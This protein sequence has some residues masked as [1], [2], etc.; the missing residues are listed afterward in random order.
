MSLALLLEQILRLAM[1]PEGGDD[2]AGARDEP[3]DA[4]GYGFVERA[5][6][7]EALTT[8]AVEARAREQAPPPVAS[9]PHEAQEVPAV[10]YAVE[11]GERVEARD[12]NRLE[13][14]DA[15][16]TVAESLNLGLHLG[17]AV[18]RIAFAATKGSEGV[19][20]LKEA[21]WLIERYIGHV[22]RPA[23]ANQY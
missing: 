4:P 20:S 19:E 15:A 2:D 23:P 5:S 1:E 18:E 14:L 6:L 12:G 22:E 16:I 11:A 7:D 13:Q 17:L 21:M 8:A 9:T 3:F 10:S